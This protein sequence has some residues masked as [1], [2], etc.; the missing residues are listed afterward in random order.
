MLP[1]M[2]DALDISNS[3][4]LE[5]SRIEFGHSP[6]KRGPHVAKRLGGVDPDVFGSGDPA[7]DC[8]RGLVSFAKG[9]HEPSF[10]FSEDVRPSDDRRTTGAVSASSMHRDQGL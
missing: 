3:E 4:E 7:C 8:R 1:F 6:F 2:I 10:S 5:S 9:S